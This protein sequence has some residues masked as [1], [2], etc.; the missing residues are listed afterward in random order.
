MQRAH[1]YEA[2]FLVNQGIDQ[3]VRG[4]ERLK[5]AQGFAAEIY[6][7]T[8]ATIEHS[9]ARVNLQCFA[10]TEQAEKRGAARYDR[11]TSE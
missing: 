9:C 10:D 6:K 4:L 2:I 8:L 3:A 5:K 7:G 11:R 1:L